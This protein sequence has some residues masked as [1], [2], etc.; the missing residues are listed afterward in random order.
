MNMSEIGIFLQSLRKSKGSTQRELADMLNVSNKTVSKWENGLG[1]PEM[2]TLLLLSD[3]YDVSVDDILRG[4]KKMKKSDDVPIERFLYIIHK[5]KHQYFNHLILSFGILLLGI[6]AFFVVES[7]TSTRSVSIVIALGFILVSILIQVFN[8]LRVRYQ[9]I[10]VERNDNYQSFLRIVFYS[11]FLILGF[12][13]WLA[14]YLFL[15]N[16]SWIDQAMNASYYSAIFPSLAIASYYT[17]IIYAIVRGFGKFS[18]TLKLS[19]IG[20]IFLASFVLIVS[21]PF[22]ALTVFSARDIAIKMQWSGVVMSTAQI[23]ED[24]AGYYKLS[25]LQLLEESNA[26]GIPSREVYDIVM[27]PD[28]NAF[29]PYV[30]YHFTSPTDYEFTIRQDFF[31]DFLIPLGHSNFDIDETTA[32]AYW[33]TVNDVQLGFELYGYLF[34]SLLQIW[35]FAGCIV[36]LVHKTK[37]KKSQI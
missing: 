35:A 29:V 31:E 20:R 25:L 10:E 1:I 11:S 26:Q 24:E 37:S 8:I 16:A 30:S 33:F 3:I 21:I 27:L 15:K 18:F 32:T 6:L 28:G 5:T 9:L 7:L 2:S 36:V 13:M 12:A 23:E 34:V 17:L 19:R 22:I 14:V 4:S